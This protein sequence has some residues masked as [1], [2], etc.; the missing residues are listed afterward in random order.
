MSGTS[1]AS[2]RAS[3]DT[4]PAGPSTGAGGADQA[5]PELDETSKQILEDDTRAELNRLAT[6]EIGT[7][8]DPASGEPRRGEP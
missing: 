5:R 7:T 3:G 1:G 4:E 8:T 2:G 6:P